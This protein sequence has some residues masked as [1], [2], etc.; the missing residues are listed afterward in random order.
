MSC[1]I[2]IRGGT[3][4]DGNGRA[5]EIGDLAVR[6]G[7]IAALGGH[8]GGTRQRLGTASGQFHG[9]EWSPFAQP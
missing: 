3:L 9:H 7:R 2:L 8:S 5:G 1:D 4:I 6:D